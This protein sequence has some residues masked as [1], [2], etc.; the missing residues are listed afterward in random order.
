META[1]NPY[2]ALPPR[3]YWRTAVA[4]RSGPHFESL[5]TPCVDIRPATR[6]ATAGSC[7]AQHISAWL[8]RHGHCWLDSEPAP[9]GMDEA[10]RRREGFGVFSFRTGNIYTARLLRQWVLWALGVEAAPDEAI[11]HEG[12]WYDPFRPC[13]P[14]RGFPSAQAMLEARSQTLDCMR[15]TLEQADVLIFT[16]G[17][18]EGWEHVDGHAYP[19]CP[20]TLR[21][22]FDAKVHRFVNQDTA[23]VIAD[24]ERSFDSLRALNPRLRFLL[25]VSPVPLTATAAD[26]HVLVATAH[27][28]AVLRAAAGAL[29]ARREDVDYFPSYELITSPAGPQRFYDENL[30]DVTADG[31]EF[32]MHHFAR[33][34]GTEPPAAAPGRP[35]P[36]PA[37]DHAPPAGAEAVCE[38]IL[39]DTW[40]TATSPAQARVCLVGDS[41]MGMLSHALG[42]AGTAHCGGMIMSGSAWF[43]NAFRLD[44]E[45]LLE[46]AADD[47]ARER[48][49]AI[50]PF[51]QARPWRL[52]GPAI[53]ITNLG[54]HTH[55]SVPSYLD[56]HMRRRGHLKL[57][58]EDSRLFFFQTHANKLAFVERLLRAGFRVVLVTD[59]PTQHLDPETS[60]MV[61]AYAAYERLACS[62]YAELGAEVFLAR[63]H[64]GGS[65]FLP[66][67]CT[68]TRLADGS[69]DLL[70]G[71][72]AYYA[73]LAR[74]LDARFG[75]SG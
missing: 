6:F 39:L 59:P 1:R 69:L 70:H 23:A 41:H 11:E 16:L 64:F 38:D 18:T 24:L 32:V 52:L 36:G 71:S 60:R 44:A 47:G 10:T 68:T 8:R 49:S 46:P 66:H 50:L 22:R 9:A 13:I 2:R 33:G 45:R 56:W 75:L 21:G 15:R 25:T 20:G 35:E 37:A 19:A 61:P 48:W 40:N 63:E 5:W 67:Y 51:F 4:R 3:N 30:R 62:A 43:E 12:A 31:V 73:D 74:A 58:V 34:L 17:L 54:L 55:V 72:E 26:A 53:V 42:Q 29:R 7:F 28:K 57:G 27:S 14:E 65:A